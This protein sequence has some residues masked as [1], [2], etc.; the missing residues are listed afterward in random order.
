MIA[1]RGLTR[2]FGARLAVEDVT[3]DVDRGEILVLL[4]PNG[5]GKTTTLRMLGG[6]LPPTSGD[7]TVAGIVMNRSTD[8]ASIRA[9][10]GLLTETPGL[11]DRLSVRTNVEVHARLHG[12]S[13]P[14]AAADRVLGRLGV[15]DRANDAAGALSK[16]LR[17]RVAL[18]RALVHEPPVLLLDEP[19]SGLDPE[20]AAGVR[21]LILDVRRQGV[22]IVLCTHNL[23][24]ADELADRIAVVKARV[25]ALGSADALTASS[26]GRTVV[27]AID[28][29]D[30]ASR[31]RTAVA[32]HF[33][34]V[35]VAGTRL[36]GRLRAGADV[37]DV[38]VALVH[39]GAR[40]RR[41]D[42]ERPSL[43]R[44][45]LSLVGAA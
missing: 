21:E 8:T 12:L 45:Y 31:W 5:A 6:L 22:A 1:T 14:H 2:R 43:E 33:D 23:S 39:A 30:D 9:R 37:A 34:D 20:A 19:T 40:V 16:G 13:N 24:E 4:G 36:R 25:L 15:A 3:L 38:V 27:V 29:E 17:Q 28:V 35:E 26:G 11:W 10:I 41:V 44:A 7:A 32:P 42:T 18:A